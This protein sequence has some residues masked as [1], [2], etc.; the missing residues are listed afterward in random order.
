VAGNDIGLPKKTGPVFPCPRHAVWDEI[1]TI[2]TAVALDSG[3]IT[4]LPLLDFLVRVQRDTSQYPASLKNHSSR[5]ESKVN[6]NDLQHVAAFP[7]GRQIR[8]TG[9]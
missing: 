1:A 5:S 3:H 6:D 8:A 7:G 2:S 9:W 4:K